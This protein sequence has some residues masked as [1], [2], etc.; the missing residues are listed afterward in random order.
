MGYLAGV[1]AVV[2]GFDIAAETRKVNALRDITARTAQVLL[3]G[4]QTAMGKAR[5]VGTDDRV[6][7]RANI[8]GHLAWHTAAIA[9]LAPDALYPSAVDLKKWVLESFIE[10]NVSEEGRAFLDRLWMEMWSEI[11]EGV[12]KPFHAALALLSVP[13]WVWVAGGTAVAGAVGFGVYK[14][15]VAAAP[16][17]AGHYLARSAR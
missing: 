8:D 11:G 4:A 6:G 2:G 15:L 5:D 17:V 1:R 7:R 10:V 14:I 13:W 3:R 12:G 9:K 16:T